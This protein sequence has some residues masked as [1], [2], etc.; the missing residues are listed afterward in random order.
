M[1][2]QNI[3]ASV[4]LRDISL[5]S[6]VVLVRVVVAVLLVSLAGVSMAL[7]LPEPVRL[8]HHGPHSRQQEVLPLLE[9]H[10]ILLGI[11]DWTKLAGLVVYPSDVVHACA[12]LPGHDSGVG[13][14]EGRHTPVLV[15]LQE[16]GALHTALRIVAE[17]PL[18]DFVWHL[19]GLK[20]YGDFEG[21]RARGVGVQSERLERG[22]C[23]EL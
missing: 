12:G 9:V 18:L 21:I 1:L 23:V 10:D 19:Q 5:Q 13:I 3:E 6:V 17:L 14:L 20:C 8:A 7:Y 4:A 2:L 11:A 22:H 15:D 16:L